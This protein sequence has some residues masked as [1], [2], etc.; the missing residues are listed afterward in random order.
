MEWA[1][2]RTMEIASFL[3]KIHNWKSPGSDKIQ[4]YWLKAFPAV[5]RHIT[6]NFDTI[7]EEPEKMPDGLTIKITY[8][9][10]KSGDC[11]AVRN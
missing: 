10:P 7:M 2:I 5:H 6:K 11:K 1:P 9:L 4:N 3:S 8:L